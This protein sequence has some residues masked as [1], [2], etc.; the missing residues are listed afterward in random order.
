MICGAKAPTS[1]GISGQYFYKRANVDATQYKT[2]DY[3][4]TNG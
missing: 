2:Y 3:F 4:S 1:H